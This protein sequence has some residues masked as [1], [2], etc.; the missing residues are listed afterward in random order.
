MVDVARVNLYGHPI[1]SVRWDPR[2][3]IAQFEYDPGFVQ[4]GIEPSP[5][6]MPVREGRVYSFGELNKTTFKGLPG[7]L[8]DSLPD[9]YG[10]ALFEKWLALTGRTS[11]NAIEALCFL[12]K[13]CMG[14]LEFEPAIEAIDTD[15]R[16]EVDSLVDVAREALADKSSF[17]VN[18][19][20]DKRPPSQRFCAS[21]PQPE[22][23]GPRQSLLSTKRLEK[24]VLDRPRHQTGST[25]ISSNWTAYQP[26]P[27]SRRLK[28]SV[29]WSTLS[30]DL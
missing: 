30:H 21:A 20:S 23:N 27:G 13:R 7:M 15:I 25:T 5:L 28:T 3:E 2:Y 6:M 12:G 29:D 11:G 8:A 1:G 24:S 19:S 18:I 9:T 16:I 26:L 22:G 14:A 10:R 17:N 4:L